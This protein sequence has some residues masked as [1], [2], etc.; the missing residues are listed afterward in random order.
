M[1]R[2]G[3][4]FLLLA[5]LTPLFFRFVRPATDFQ[6]GFGDGVRGALFGVSFGLLLLGIKRGKCLC[7]RDED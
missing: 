6:Q 2:V 5:N 4:V 7:S 1:I 3:L